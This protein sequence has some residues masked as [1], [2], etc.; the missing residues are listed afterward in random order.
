MSAYEVFE[1]NYS[2]A[3]CLADALR[4]IGFTNVEVHKDAQHLFDYHGKVRPQKAHVIVRRQYIEKASNDAGW[5]F[6]NGTCY[7]HI[8]DFD[9]DRKFAPDVQKQLTMKYTE[10]YV[11]KV[12]KGW[13]EKAR[14]VEPDGSIRI[15]LTQ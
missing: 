12:T 5:Q 13:K 6:F 11:G 3:E 4:D 14:T 10:R 15:R 7:A 1:V 9:R 2:D 8:S